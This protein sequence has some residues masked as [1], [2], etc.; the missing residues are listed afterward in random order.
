MSINLCCIH[1]NDHCNI[2]TQI[3]TF[4]DDVEHVYQAWI[5]F[6]NWLQCVHWMIM[7]INLCCNGLSEGGNISKDKIILAYPIIVKYSDKL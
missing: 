6:R 5:C 3:V 7:F 1:G 2:S 4:Y